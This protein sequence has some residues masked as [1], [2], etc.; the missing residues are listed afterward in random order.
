MSNAPTVSEI[1][2]SAPLNLT[3]TGI[4]N[5]WH[6]EL[7]A[8]K[9]RIWMPD[10]SWGNVKQPL[11]REWNGD[12]WCDPKHVIEEPDYEKGCARFLE[13]VVS[14]RYCRPSGAARFNFVFQNVTDRSTGDLFD[15]NRVYIDRE[16][17]PRLPDVEVTVCD[18]FGKQ[19][20]RALNRLKERA[21]L[22]RGYTLQERLRQRM[23]WLSL[24]RKVWLARA[25]FPEFCERFTP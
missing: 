15:W 18:A 16:S 24:A 12:A 6:T 5:N 8:N 4:C 11:F 3:E 25:G 19:P 22:A 23:C 10:G 21:N 9:G 20:A 2:P 7:E 17:L 14:A 1:D 13:S